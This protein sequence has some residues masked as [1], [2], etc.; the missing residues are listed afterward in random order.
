MHQLKLAKRGPILLQKSKV[1]GRLIFREIANREAIADSYSLNCVTE[2]DL[3]GPFWTK[4]IERHCLGK[5]VGHGEEE[6]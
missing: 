5:E 4:R 1:A 2:V 6:I 3:T